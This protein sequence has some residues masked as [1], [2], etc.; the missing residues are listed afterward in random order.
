MVAQ[1][2]KCQLKMVEDGKYY[3]NFTTIKIKGVKMVGEL[4]NFL[5]ALAPPK[6]N[7][8]KIDGEIT[9]LGIGLKK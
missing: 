4:C 5:L 2:Y 8:Q 9:L 7:K 3:I 6:K 1:Q